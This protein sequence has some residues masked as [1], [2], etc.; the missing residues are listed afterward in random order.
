M[1]WAALEAISL[2]V[3]EYQRSYAGG[4]RKD[5]I[6]LA[7]VRLQDGKSKDQRVEHEQTDPRKCFS[8][9]ECNQY[10][11]QVLRFRE[12]LRSALLTV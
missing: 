12:R 5:M 6:P 3:A 2:T 11:E 4:A 7:R 1:G 10:Q 8:Y 9:I